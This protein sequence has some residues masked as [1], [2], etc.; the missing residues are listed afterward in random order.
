MGAG[1]GSVMK[2]SLGTLGLFGLLALA[3]WGFGNNSSFAGEVKSTAFQVQGITCSACLPPIRGE[4]FKKPG[5][6]AMTADLEQG[7][8][9]IDHRPPLSEEGIVRTLADL[10]YPAKPVQ[11][12]AAQAGNKPIAGGCSGCGPS[13]CAAAAT[14]WRELFRKVWR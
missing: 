3:W 10:G 14:S 5:M 9:R 6:V 7:V 1:N 12:G 8:L 13:G 4:L 2:Y 11:K